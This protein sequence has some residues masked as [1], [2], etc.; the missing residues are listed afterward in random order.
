MQ[1]EFSYKSEW[2]VLGCY[3]MIL[4]VF[5]IAFIMHTIADTVGTVG[6]IVVFFVYIIVLSMIMFFLENSKGSFKAE[7]KSVEF[8]KMYFKKITINYNDVKRISIERVFQKPE[9]RG[10]VERYVEI[11]KFHQKDGEVYEFRNNLEIDKEMLANQPEK[12]K[13]QFEYG[14]FWRLF[15]YIRSQNSNIDMYYIR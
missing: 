5:F 8:T 6:I 2:C 13:Q 12:L 3:V 14:V 4:S 11:I 7:E 10:D 1:G 9:V 15:E